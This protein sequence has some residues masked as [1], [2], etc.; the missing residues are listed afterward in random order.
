MEKIKL[1]N[2]VE[3]PVM[4]LGTFPMNKLPLVKTIRTAAQM[5]YSAL[6]TSA[7]YQNEKAVG[8]GIKLSGK[9]REEFFVSTKISNT[10]QYK[11]DAETALKESLKKLKLKYVDLYLMHWPVP[12]TFLKTWKEMEALYKKGLVRAI[13]VCNFHQHHLEKL[14]EVADVMP[15]VN[16]V[17]L[18]P[19][20]AQN[21]LT[22]FCSQHGIVMEA[23]SPIARMDKRLI[24]NPTLVKIASD[25]NKSVVQTILR[26]DY[27]KGIISIPKSSN[28][29]RLKEN[30]S[31]FDFSL[32]P[33][34]MQQINSLNENY[35]VRYDPDNC[36]FKKL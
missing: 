11:M 14:F 6:D 21:E 19:L 25:H 8:W 15:V 36:D 32:S 16:Q 22:D 7:A 18:H 24:E 28:P 33:E 2:G 29:L 12:E 23:Y 1:N 27:Q 34:E 31:I 20:L 30:I 4:G 13:G 9:K 3:M 10:Q 26:W 17:E 35:R 5:G